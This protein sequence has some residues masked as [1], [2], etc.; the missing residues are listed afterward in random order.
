M[1][2]LQ[3]IVAALPTIK[4]AIDNGE[5]FPSFESARRED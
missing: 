5:S 3:R 1:T 2:D 4:Y